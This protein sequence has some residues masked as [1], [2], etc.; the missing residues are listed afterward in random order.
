MEG[1]HGYG[2]FKRYNRTNKEIIFTSTATCY[3]F[4]EEVL[5]LGSQV[6]QIT[7]EVKGFRFAKGKVR[8]HCGA[9]T[10]LRNGKYNDK[11]RY[12]CKSCRKTFT[13]F[14]VLQPNISVT[15]CTGSNGLNYLKMI[16]KP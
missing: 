4:L 6:S 15:I 13:D 10:V 12:I 16:K 9:E 11:Q 5:V 3:S 7:Q 1:G 14:T 8:P 2:K